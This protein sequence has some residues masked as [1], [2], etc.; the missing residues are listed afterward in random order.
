MAVS[1]DII[2]SWRSPARVMRKLLGMGRREDRALA[3]LIAACLVIFVA[4]WPRLSREA[5]LAAEGAPPLEAVLAITF[6]AMLMIWPLMAYGLAGLTHLVARLFGGR[7]TWYSA[8]LALFWSLLATSPA[9]LFHGLV[10]GFI[11]PGP[12]QTVA[13]VIL[14]VAFLAIWGISLREA[15]RA[16]EA[17]TSP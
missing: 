1:S 16:P 12:E 2:A 3:I 4:Q 13:G 11:G 15:E 5:Y 7:G 8:R 17:D 6:F 14:M 9:W 10:A